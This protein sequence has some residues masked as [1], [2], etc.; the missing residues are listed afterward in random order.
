MLTAEHCRARAER[1]RFWLLTAPDH[2][3]AAR[4]RGFVERYNALATRAETAE[5]LQFF[6]AGAAQFKG[7]PDEFLEKS[8]DSSHERDKPSSLTQHLPTSSAAHYAKSVSTEISATDPGMT[9]VGET[10]NVLGRVEGEVCRPIV[11]I[12]DGGQLEGVVVAQELTV[13]G[14]FKGTIHANRVTLA[15]SAVVEGEIFYR[16]LAIDANAW[17]AGLSRPE[18]NLTLSWTTAHV[19]DVPSLLQHPFK[20]LNK[21]EDKMFRKSKGSSGEPLPPARQLQNRASASPAALDTTDDSF[22][23]SI[24][25]GMTVV[26]KISSEGAVNV[27]GRVEGEL[28]ASIVRIS[29]GGQV[30]G[31]V[32]A[33][34][35]SVGGR[36]KGTIHA[37]RV[38]LTS[39]AVVEGEIF[40]RCLVIEENAWFSGVSHPGESL[41]DASASAQVNVAPSPSQYAH[42]GNAQINGPLEKE[43][44]ADTPV[45]PRPSSP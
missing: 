39:T 35:L 40:H 20:S 45:L 18:E 32:A 24:G 27:F 19:N 17:F 26:G 44:G 37:H 15:T 23:S 21:K 33:Q 11:W 5:A 13:D 28:H 36:F 42:N 3:T 29:D 34:E 14:R 22:N 30:E 38:A 6:A 25:A 8:R 9:I 2:A 1:F 41:V 4:L 31:I 43:V 7:N 12:S 16:S 10:A